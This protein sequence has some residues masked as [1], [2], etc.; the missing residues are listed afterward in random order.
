MTVKRAYRTEL[1]PNNKQKTLLSRS[2]GTPRF[3]WNWGL[4][5][6]IDENRATGRSSN[7]IAQHRQLNRYKKAFFPWM[8]EVSKCCPQE[9]LR[10]LD[11][12]Y[13]N[14]YQGRA[15]FPRFKTKKKMGMLVQA[16]RCDQRLSR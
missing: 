15:G 13:K 1:D 9:A 7:A 8:Y 11:R 6:R 14:F 5:K 2:A 4:Q 3:A 16:D 12:A 10:D